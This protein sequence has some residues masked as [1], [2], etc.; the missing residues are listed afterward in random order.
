MIEVQENK[1]TTV[2]ES[3][4]RDAANLAILRKWLARGGAKY[5]SDIGGRKL[6]E[7]RKS[8]ASSARNLLALARLTEATAKTSTKE[9]NDDNA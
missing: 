1:G 3:L 4:K 5:A 6:S 7:L 9:A 8:I 2:Q